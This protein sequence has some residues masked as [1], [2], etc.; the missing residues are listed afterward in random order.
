MSDAIVIVSAARTP[1]GGFQG[2]FAP[3]SAA[4][5]GGAAIAAA[6]EWA[7]VAPADVDELLMGCVLRPA[8]V[9]PRRA[10][11]ASGPAFPTACR[12]RR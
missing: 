2:A 11:R 6:L 12:R 8:R 3:L 10:R 7:E 4:E 5:L 1:M 9:R